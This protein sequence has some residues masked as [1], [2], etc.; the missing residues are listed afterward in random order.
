MAYVFYISTE[1][2]IQYHFTY[3]TPPVHTN[4][5]AGRQKVSLN[6]T[7]FW[8]IHQLSKSMQFILNF[9]FNQMA[10]LMQFFSFRWQYGK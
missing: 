6:P 7:T 8:N 10:L 5:S 4:T 1:H 2:F 9:Q 3:F